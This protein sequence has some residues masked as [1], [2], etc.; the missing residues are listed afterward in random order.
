MTSLVD[1][2]RV[3]RRR[4]GTLLVAL[5]LV[6]VVVVA[7]SLHETR[8][9]RATA[10]VTVSLSN[11]AAQITG[12]AADPT[13]AQDPERILQTDANGARGSN[14]ASMVVKAV[15]TSGLDPQSFLRDSTVAPDPTSNMLNFSVVNRNPDMARQL[16][17]AYAR[18]FVVWRKAL[19]G[20]PYLTAEAPL[21]AQF[22]RLQ[23]GR[24]R[25][26]ECSFLEK[27]V[28]QLETLGRVQAGNASVT[29]DASTYAQVQP[30][31]V[32]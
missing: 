4:L 20:A 1:Y 19:D 18:Q 7:Y 12:T 15:P 9:Y 21:K 13:L 27:Q 30:S 24:V 6:P 3:V 25:S 28:T 8:L 16:A 31:T 17:E 29:N 22:A 26:P 2:V 32:R 23:C 5:V 11:V 10:G 14:V